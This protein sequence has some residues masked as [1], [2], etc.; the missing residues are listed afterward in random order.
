MIRRVALAVV[1][2]GLAGCGA[3]AAG[4]SPGP[5]PDATALLQRAGAGLD[6]AAVVHVTGTI[7]PPSEPAAAVDVVVS[8]SGSTGTVGEGGT[9]TAVVETGGH[10]YL[11]DPGASAYVDSA[12]AGDTS[13]ATAICAVRDLPA[14]AAFVTGRSATPPV[15]ITGSETV[16]GR[17]GVII[18]DSSG[19]FTATV[20][21]DGSAELL[22]V[23]TRARGRELEVDLQIAWPASA[24]AVTPVAGASPS[25]P[26]GVSLSQLSTYC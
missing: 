8:T 14:F 16:G 3:P 13:E 11:R 5:T 22:H 20:S 6:R 2:A 21:D 4:S 7:T 25:A 10:V 19:A 12:T 17:S 23:V 15:S 9:Q 24:P 26:A 1:A 18:S